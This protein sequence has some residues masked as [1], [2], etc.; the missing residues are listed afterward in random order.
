MAKGSRG[1]PAAGISSSPHQESRKASWRWCL[2]L[3]EAREDGR[4]GGVFSLRIQHYRE[5]GQKTLKEF[6]SP[7]KRGWRERPR[8]E[9]GDRED[10]RGSQAHVGPKQA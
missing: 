8:S 1:Y 2:Q 9:A 10:N 4:E 5:E 3:R 6:K 7:K